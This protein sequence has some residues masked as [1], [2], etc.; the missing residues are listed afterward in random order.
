[1]STMIAKTNNCSFIPKS[2][3]HI[4][5][6][7]AEIGRIEI[8]G[9]IRSEKRLPFLSLTNLCSIQPVDLIL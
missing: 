6:K 4:A 8:M 3:N 9:W 7:K 2:I 1:M 5:F